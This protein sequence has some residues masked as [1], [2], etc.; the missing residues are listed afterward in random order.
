MFLTIFTKCNSFLKKLLTIKVD[1][2]KI[3]LYNILF[4]G[5]GGSMF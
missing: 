5:A 4:F 2:V 3:K 1:F